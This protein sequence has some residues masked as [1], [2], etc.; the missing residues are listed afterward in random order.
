MRRWVQAGCM[1]AVMSGL[2]GCATYGDQ[3]QAALIA[4]E[5][6]DY[7]TAENQ[8]TV[9]LET[10]ARNE[11]LYFLEVGMVRHLAGDYAGSNAM[12]QRAD[13]L[14]D[15]L[16]FNSLGVQFQNFMSSPAM[17]TYH[18]ATYEFAYVNYFKA[19]NYLALAQQAGDNQWLDAARVEARR[20]EII[21]NEF[22]ANEGDYLTVATSEDEQ[23]AG[24]L[25]VL[26]VLNG[27]Y[28]DPNS[29]IYRDDAWARFLAGI[30]YENLRE[31]DSARV[32]Y[33]AA[34]NAYEQGYAEQYQLGAEATRL[35]WT[36]TVRMMRT[37]GGWADEWPR[38]VEAKGLSEE[39]TRPLAADEAML[40]VVEHTGFI[41]PIGELNLFLSKREAAKSL[42]LEP[43]ITGDEAQQ[44]EQLGW[45][46]LH[47]ADTGIID[48]LARYQAGGL[49][50]VLDDPLR[51]K[52]VQLGSLWDV[53]D[54]VGL[55]NG[56]GPL[57]V[58][59][60]VPY[61]PPAYDEPTASELRLNGASHGTV[62]AMANIEQLARQER[63]R[64]AQDEMMA[65]LL[66]ETIKNA[67][68]QWVSEVAS[69]GDDGLALLF[70]LAGRA[71]ATA[72]ARAET[73]HWV[74]L[75]SWAR[76]N[77]VRYN[78]VAGEPI[79]L[80]L[81][82]DEQTLWAQDVVLQPGKVNIFYARTFGH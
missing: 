58:R 45:F 64:L 66:R 3:Q 69:S 7:A 46:T 75:P 18:G 24:F 68:N 41:P 21:L 47:Y 27:Q 4:I 8:F 57:G 9:A 19:L 33:Q 34:A 36:S 32:A 50:Q 10:Q 11:L 51:S 62:V 31:W 39:E 12:L 73:R 65:A 1:V 30:A 17:G 56:I 42:V 16:G 54:E 13:E 6:G 82:A 63:L 60:S 5:Q 48:L 78:S 70:N 23:A 38:L 25:Q 2:T 61:Y 53:A 20:L 80:S 29:L 49:W 28:V 44:L 67:A 74:T 81:H 14:R 59:V 22:A 43:V 55:L 72:T 77:A 37:G 35:A 52:Q 26:R 40:L 79:A 76:A 15:T 71:A